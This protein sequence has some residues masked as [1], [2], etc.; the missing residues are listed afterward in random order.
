MTGP[1]VDQPDILRVEPSVT[2]HKI[3]K[4]IPEGMAQ[5]RRPPRGKCRRRARHRPGMDGKPLG[6]L[7]R[8]GSIQPGILLLMVR[9]ET[10]QS[11]L[12]GARQSGISAVFDKPLTVDRLRGALQR[13]LA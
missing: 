1:S 7:I 4:S 9:S 10:D 11:R 3:V 12:A 6:R 13:L 8:A 5:P 2:Q